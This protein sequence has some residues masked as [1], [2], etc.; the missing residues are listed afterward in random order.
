MRTIVILLVTST[1]VLSACGGWRDSRVNP[2]NWFGNSRPAPTPSAE[3][4]ST[5][6]LLPQRTSIFQRDKSE[7]YEGTLVAEVTELV[8]ERTPTGGILRVAGVTTLQG[9]YDVRLTSET[10]GEPVDGV[11]TFSLKA[12][13]PD[14]QGVGNTTTRTVQ[15]GQF[16]S[17]QV[18]ERTKTVRVIGALGARTTARR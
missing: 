3:P 15:A 10:D 13:Q 8:V 16:V 7:R 6:P 11:L 9:A 4:A 1:L 2:S 18:L 5:N 14:D 12:V 17:T